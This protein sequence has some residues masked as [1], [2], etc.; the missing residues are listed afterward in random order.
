MLNII[1]VYDYNMPMLTKLYVQT[2]LFY[3]YV[4]L[5]L[6]NFISYSY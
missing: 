6:V 1:S 4:Y 3:I 5:A 2:G